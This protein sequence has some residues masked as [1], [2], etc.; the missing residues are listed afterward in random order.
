VIA[1]GGLKALDERIKTALENTDTLRKIGA[2]VRPTVFFNDQNSVTN[3]LGGMAHIEKID[4]Q[5]SGENYKKAR[6]PTKIVVHPNKHL[7]AAPILTLVS[8]V[9][10]AITAERGEKFDWVYTLVNYSF[11][12][13]EDS[14]NTRD[15]GVIFRLEILY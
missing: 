10:V 1:V 7:S 2:Q 11:L 6:L 13:T 15:K 9:G 14:E 8:G 4:I 3:D 5:F 12:T